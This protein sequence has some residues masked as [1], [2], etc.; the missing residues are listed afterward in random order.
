MGIQSSNLA[1]IKNQLVSKSNHYRVYAIDLNFTIFI[2][3]KFM[4]ACMGCDSTENPMIM[5]SLVSKKK[6]QKKKFDNGIFCC[7]SK[8]IGKTYIQYIM[9]FD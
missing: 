3:K 5:V 2:I 7:V 6:K 1:C 9:F 8:T 4:L